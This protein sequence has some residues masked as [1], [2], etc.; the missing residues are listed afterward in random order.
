MIYV[1]RNLS[2]AD[3]NYSNTEREAREILFV[4]TRLKQF[5]LGRRVTLKADHQALLPRQRN[6]ENSISKSYEMGDSADGIW[7]RIE[8]YIRRTDPPRRLDFDDDD[9]N[10]RFSFALDIIYFVQSEL[11]TQSDIKTELWSNRP[12]KDVIKRIKSG[13]WKQCSEAEKGFEQQKDALTIHNVIIFRG[14]VPF[15]PPKLSLMV[16]TKAHETHPGKNATETEVPMMAWWPVVNQNVLR[17]VSKCK[18]CKEN[19]PNLGKTVSSTWPEAEVWE[20]LHM[21]WG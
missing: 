4:V 2:Q 17:Y 18:E 11:V 9:D 1:S 21:D 16:M 15:I 5:L 10:D 13:I 14:I 7:F 8:I 6:S 3:Q 12:F 19:R 20:R